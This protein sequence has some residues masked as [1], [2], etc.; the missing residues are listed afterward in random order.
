MLLGRVDIDAHS[1]GVK[2]K[3]WDPRYKCIEV[4]LLIK[5]SHFTKSLYRMFSRI[6]P[7]YSYLNYH[8]LF[9]EEIS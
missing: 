2:V 9:C 6:F 1:Q 8:K 7:F 4:Y 3:E 5:S